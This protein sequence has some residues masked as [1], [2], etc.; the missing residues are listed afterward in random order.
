M[1]TAKI[2]KLKT[3]IYFTAT[4]LA[5]VL[6]VTTSSAHYLVTG[7][8]VSVIPASALD[9][10]LKGQVTVL[11]PTEFTI[12][13]NQ[14]YSY[15]RGLVEVDFFRTGQT[16]RQ[17]FT[18]PRSTG[19]AAVMQSFVTG[20]GGAAYNF[21][22]SLDGT[23]WVPAASVTHPLVDGDSDF[24]TIAPAWLYAS[25]DITSIGAATKLEV[26]YSA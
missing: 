22:L 1:S 4:W 6:T 17:I 9:M 10:T 12:S 3:Q 20:A 24:Q 13:T 23:H 19:T 11:S 26:L 8:V 7:D 18:L 5:N 16:G 15:L 2:K 14:P 21:D 25:I